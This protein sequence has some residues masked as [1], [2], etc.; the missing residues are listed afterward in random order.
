[1]KLLARAD[2]VL[3]LGTRLGP[4]GTLPQYGLDYWPQGAKIIQVDSELRVLGL[5][6]PV[7]LAIN[8]DARAAAAAITEEL[9]RLQGQRPRHVER[10]ATIAAEKAAWAEALPVEQ[11]QARAESES[12]RQVSGRAGR[13]WNPTMG[14]IM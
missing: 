10:I 9:R 1:M 7:A 13:G 11:E 2:V 14:G 6:K 4:F 8:G 12:A 5:V 3:A